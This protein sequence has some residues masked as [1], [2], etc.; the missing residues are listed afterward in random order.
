MMYI[1]G[2]SGKG[3]S[4]LDWDKSDK[5]VAIQLLSDS[6]ESQITTATTP[7]L[8][9]FKDVR[10]VRIV[11]FVIRLQHANKENPRGVGMVW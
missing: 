8:F 1:L 3:A 4:D 10:V 5:L 11:A 9:I 2:L 7:H 6:S